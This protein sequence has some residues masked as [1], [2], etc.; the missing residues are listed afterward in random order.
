MLY[1][2]K[3]LLEDTLTTV[4]IENIVDTTYQI[5]YKLTN[6]TYYWRVIA[7]DGKTQSQ[8][9]NTKATFEIIE[10]K[11]IINKIDAD[12]TFTKDK[13]PYFIIKNITIPHGIS[14]TVEKGTE[15]IFA[16]NATLYVMG[17]IKILGEKYSPVLLNA[18]ETEWG[19]IFID[20]ENA[21][22]V[23]KYV[24]FNNGAF[25]SKNA[26][27]VLENVI[28]NARNKTLVFGEER[29]SLIWV[30]KGNF[31]FKRCEVYGSGK[32]ESLNI[33]FANT[34]VENSYLT[35]IPDAIELM[36]V[37]NGNIRNN[38]VCY[39]QDDA[40]DLNGCSNISIENNLLYNN[41]DKGI[42]IGTEQ[43]GPCT[44]IFVK[45]NLII[46]NKYGISVKDSSFAKAENTFFINNK[47][48]LE[49]HLKN[50]WKQYKIGGNLS[51]KSC[52]FVDTENKI[53]KHDDNS[54]IEILNSYSTKVSDSNIKQL[55]KSKI[56]N[57]IK[58]SFK[59]A[60]F[61]E[62]K[63]LDFVK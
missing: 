1:G 42:S 22:S 47:T 23:F 32:G 21:N 10:R 6:G 15:I 19:A 62:Y 3:F 45:N 52:Y 11:N 46:N 63:L 25:R 18:E 49:A 28:F 59:N 30:N 35:S 61:K 5:K 29:K 40:I 44:N 26:S 13:S 16:K 38:I 41:K 51:V 36:N 54:K 27:V 7:S 34:I 8:G 20:N 57:I 60:Y 2:K 56:D 12:I 37:S 33:N 43:F 24:V 55:E 9:F 17:D 58:E 53:S 39:S 14:L 4:K 50:N 31:T 48:D